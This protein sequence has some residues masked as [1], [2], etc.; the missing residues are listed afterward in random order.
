MLD[1]RR[2]LQTAQIMPA[3]QYPVFQML[4][5]SPHNTIPEL[6]LWMQGVKVYSHLHI[7]EESARQAV[8]D[9]YNRMYSDGPRACIPGPDEVRVHY[10]FQS[11]VRTRQSSVGV[12]WAQ[13]TRSTGPSPSHIHAAASAWPVYAPERTHHPGCKYLCSSSPP[14]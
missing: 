3:L 12:K 14:S 8:I 9:A 4:S 5:A 1:W 10:F 6:Q 13:G 11:T 7:E 2:Q